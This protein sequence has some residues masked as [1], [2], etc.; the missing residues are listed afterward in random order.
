VA[1]ST[2]TEALKDSFH[3]GLEHLLRF[4]SFVLARCFSTLTISSG[5][6]TRET[7]VDILWLLL[8]APLASAV[9]PVV[10]T[11]TSSVRSPSMA[12]S[13]S[14]PWWHRVVICHVSEEGRVR[15]CILLNV[16]FSILHI[17]VDDGED[18]L[19]S[20]VWFHDL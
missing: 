14:H 10:A 5:T 17:L 8:L 9:T 18:S 19:G 13:S 11:S 16:S 3:H 15:L 6:L 7:L 12:T 2:T 20:L 4:S 1:A